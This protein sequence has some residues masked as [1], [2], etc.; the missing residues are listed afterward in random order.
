LKTK[1]IVCTDFWVSAAAAIWLVMW[2]LFSFDGHYGYDDI[3][4]LK[5]AHSL[6]ERTFELNQPFSYRLG[7]TVPLAFFMRFFGIEDH[8]ALLINIICSVLLFWALAATQENLR[9]KWFTVGVA[10]SCY[11]WLWYNSKVYADVIVGFCH[12]GVVWV[13]WSQRQSAN[14]SKLKALLLVFFLFWGFMAKE[15]IVFVIPLFLLALWQDI[16]EGENTIFWIWTGGMVLLG[17]AV[18]LGFSYF[19]TGSALHRFELIVQNHYFNPCS[20]DQMPFWVTLK[21]ILWGLPEGLTGWGMAIALS[22]VCLAD[23]SQKLWRQAFWSAFLS[24]NFLTTSTNSYLPMCLEGR[25]FLALVPLGA[26]LTAN[27]LNNL[28]LGLIPQ[29]ALWVWIGCVFV[30][31]WFWAGKLLP[32]YL[33]LCLLV[34]LSLFFKKSNLLLGS[35]FV[36]LFAHPIYVMTKPS[37]TLYSSQ[38]ELLRNTI[39]HGDTVISDEMSARIADYT[40]RFQN[41]VMSFQQTRQLSRLGENCIILFNPYS[42][43][44]LRRFAPQSLTLEAYLKESGLELTLIGQSKNVKLFKL[45]QKK[46][47][48]ASE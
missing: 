45:K 21:R 18:F 42:S 10:A 38:K 41:V 9:T 20:Y 48:S 11:Y 2:I 30:S 15:T 28:Y 14:L 6:N 36:C 4:Y 13:I 7:L 19:F 47:N 22:F 44:Y 8:S 27:G 24:F 3:E 37:E 16:Q 25:H 23:K 5:I 34:G 31:A 32:I 17:F 33:I 26:P 12:A 39:K 29:K 43:D 40:L 1:D 35:I 46:F